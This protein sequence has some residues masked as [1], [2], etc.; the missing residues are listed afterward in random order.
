MVTRVFK[1]IDKAWTSLTSSWS[2]CN[3]CIKKDAAIA[4]LVILL[5]WS[6]I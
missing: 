5:I 2:Y 4:I 3:L 6:V 1:F